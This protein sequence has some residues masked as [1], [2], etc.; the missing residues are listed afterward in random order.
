MSPHK[1]PASDVERLENV[2]A[3]LC[4]PL[5]GD[6]PST[7]QSRAKAE[8]SGID[9]A[10]WGAEIRAKAEAQVDAERGARRLAEAGG[11]ALRADAVTLPPTPPTPDPPA[12]QRSVRRT[13][14]L[15]AFLAA[16]AAG[17]VAVL[18]VA[19]KLDFREASSEGSATSPTVQR[20]EPIPSGETGTSTAAPLAAASSAPPQT[21][22]DAG[23]P[24]RPATGMPRHPRKSP[25]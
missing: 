19:V 6:D 24:R 16:A 12:P 4:Q 5:D 9:F 7:D 20:L 14:R 1:P 10:A 11:D 15:V 3:G 13:A 8:A 22:A 25:K 18:G 17:I 2:I 23:A 21:A